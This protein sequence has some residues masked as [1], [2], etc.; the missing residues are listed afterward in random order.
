MAPA[1]SIAVT[2]GLMVAAAGTGAPL[3]LVA[4]TIPIIFIGIAFHRLCEEHP[5]AGSTYAWSRLAFGPGV[6]AFGAWIVVLSYFFAAVAAVVP[7]GIYTLDLAA[8]FGMVPA[9]WSDNAL[10]VAITGSMW[11][12][13]ASLLL[14]GGIRPTARVS[15]L[16]LLFEC[17]VLIGFAVLAIKGVPSTAATAHANT[18]FFTLGSGGLEGFLAAMVLAVWVTDGWE[19]SSYSSE[20]NQG[21]SRIPGIGG[22]IGLILTVALI[23]VCMISFMHAAPVAGLAGH[24]D[25]TL[26]YVAGL[27]GGGWRSTVMIATVLVSTAATLWT[28]QL[29]ISRGIFSMARD[30]LFP[31]A[32][33]AV[34]PVFGTPYVAIAAVN[35][36]VF[37]ITVL[38]GLLPSASNALTE[39]VNATAVL[40]N[41]T[42]ILTGASCIVHFLRKGTPITDVTRVVLPAIGTIAIAALLDLNFRSQSPLDQLIAAITIGLGIAY[43]AGVVLLGRTKLGPKVATAPGKA[44]G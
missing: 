6:G 11:V 31:S 37:V 26:A 16:F 10:A 18:H 43:A 17:V 27:L 34:H 1:Y 22:L 23:L 30:R 8:H 12:I 40:L 14:I 28:T 25:D 29:G 13:V 33:T 5:D 32:L 38:T 35:A 9:S 7:A 15:G 42:F 39:V 4:L 2:F 41:L 21:S 3:S 19:V 36:G 20:E 24:T 44:E